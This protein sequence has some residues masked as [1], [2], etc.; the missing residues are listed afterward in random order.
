[1]LKNRLSYEF[2]ENG[3][4]FFADIRYLNETNDTLSNGS[5]LV[6]HSGKIRISSYGSISDGARF[7]FWILID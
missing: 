7:E 6:S 4:K 1:M 3:S 2:L 5:D